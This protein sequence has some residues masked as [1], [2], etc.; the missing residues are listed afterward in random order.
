MDSLQFHTII[1]EIQKTLK[2]LETVES[3]EPVEPFS[4]LFNKK[5]SDELVQTCYLL[6]KDYIFQY[7]LSVSNPKFHENM[8][9]HI[10]D[11]LCEQIQPL[12]PPENDYEADINIIIQK[13]CKLFYTHV[14]PRRSF[15]RT[16]IR[17]HI[18]KKGLIERIEKLQ[19]KPQHE[20]RT[21]EW[22]EFR[23]NVLTA[24]N[25]WK[26]FG[27]DAAQ[28]QLIYEKC[29]PIDIDKYNTV[30]IQ[31]PLHWG[32]KYE[33]VSILLYE[34]QYN[35][36]IKDY[37]C[38]PHD[39]YSF[40]AASPDGINESHD[41]PRYGR[42]LEIKNVVNREITGIPKLEYWIQMQLQMETCDLNE[43]DFLET[44]FHEYEDENE[45]LADGSFT[46]TEAKDPKGIILY[47]MKEGKPLL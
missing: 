37:G 6:L 29:M 27:S 1:S 16:F 43:C 2:S 3:V 41:S 8:C 5:E 19:G 26:A 34:S 32:Q 22:Y 12:L 4:Y 40:L 33:P 11:L 39:K 44:R 9:L 47:F 14:I 20:Q 25:A 45:F 46:E 7:P 15:K 38:L 10:Y 24:S 21:P 13:A 30:N 23:S 18:E 28:N 36:R 42:M 31:S 17:S 35:T